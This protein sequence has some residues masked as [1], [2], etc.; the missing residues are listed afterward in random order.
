[1]NKGLA[2]TLVIEGINFSSTLDEN[3]VEIGSNNGI[4]KNASSRLLEVKLPAELSVGNHGLTVTVNGKRTHIPEISAI[5][6][7]NRPDV[8]QLRAFFD[9]RNGD[10][11]NGELLEISTG[12]TGRPFKVANLDTWV[13]SEV[14]WFTLYSNR[15]KKFYLPATNPAISGQ[16]NLLQ[17]EEL[18]IVEVRNHNL[19][20][21]DLSVV[22]PNV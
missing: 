18:M 10:K 14:A 17:C 5:Y 8:E 7:L 4:V 3:I 12:S 9:I 11:T 21:I 1:M 13:Y 20:S 22:Y 19:T 15:L 6:V 16:L 2:G